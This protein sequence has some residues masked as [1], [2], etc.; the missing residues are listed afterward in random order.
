MGILRVGSGCRSA[1]LSHELYHEMLLNVGL[2]YYEIFCPSQ[3]LMFRRGMRGCLTTLFSNSEDICM[4]SAN[5]KCMSCSL[6][7]IK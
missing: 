1:K 2:F 7:H 3:T 4:E 5:V 6:F